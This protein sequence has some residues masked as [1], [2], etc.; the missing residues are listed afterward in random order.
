[1][2]EE[3]PA[4]TGAA[5]GEDSVGRNTLFSFLTQMATAAG[6][7]VLTIYLVRA[8][9]PAEYGVFAIAV[10]LSG[11]LMI[12]SDFGITQSAS[13]FIAERRGDDSAVA[14]VIA[15][16]VRLKLMIGSVFAIALFALA[17]PIASAYGEPTLTWPIRW[18]SIVV[19]C[20]SMMSFYRYAFSSLRRVQTGFRIVAAESVAETGASLVIVILAGGAAGAAAGR[21]AGFAFGLFV[22]VLL[23]Y[24]AFGRPAFARH[25]GAAVSRR[26]LLRYAGALLVIDAAFALSAQ[27]SPLMIG[28]YLGATE[29]GIFQAPAKLI[30]FLQYPGISI[31]NAVTPGLARVEGRE[32]DVE[33]FKSAL[34]HIIVFQALLMAPVV[35]WA[36]PITHLLLGSG[37][38]R[39]AD[40]LRALAPYIFTAGIAPI[41]ALGVNYLG[42]A[43]LRLPISVVDVILELALTAFLLSQIGLLGAAYASD[44]SALIYVPLHLWILR[45]LIALPMRPLALSMARSL[46][47]AA[48]M[49]AVL[50]AFGTHD[51]SLFGWLAGSI[52]GL[53]AFMAVLLVTRQVTVG[54]LRALG[55]FVRR[56]LPGGRR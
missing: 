50:F 47:A 23:T 10:G 51:L 45:R 56:R 12:P 13:R 52:G 25:R 54:E 31:A 3:R 38:E 27:A 40:V 34:R 53:A 44:I 14:A 28:A 42:E 24:R 35:V 9:G 17:A 26:R 36:E 18:V 49:A 33:P 19:V 16:A 7:A 29:V 11:L 39:S 5:R 6:T 46:L 48:A 55:A 8:L 2:S 37:Y 32:P 20:A 41:V 22:A 1:V 4:P 21:A 43:R 30:V 15:D